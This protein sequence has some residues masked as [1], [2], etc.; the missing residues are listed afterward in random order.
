MK[1]TLTCSIAFIVLVVMS[2]GRATEDQQTTSDTTAISLLSEG[3]AVQIDKNIKPDTLHFAEEGAKK[4]EKFV[5]EVLPKTYTNRH[6]INVSGLS[7]DIFLLPGNIVKL[8]PADSTY[9]LVTVKALVNKGS[10]PSIT[11]ID[12]GIL[13]SNKINRNA[14]FNASFIIGGVSADANSLVELVIQDISKSVLPD[15]AID[16]KS[17]NKIV[18]KIPNGSLSSYFFIKTAVLTTVNH[19]KFKSANFNAK[20]NATYVTAEG[21]VFS[22]NEKFVSE[23]MVSIDLIS[24]ADI[25][26]QPNSVKVKRTTLSEL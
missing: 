14:A 13:Y 12:N 17:L 1:M 7:Y 23:R 11:A 20:V 25:I 8:N 24:F 2:C 21:K 15:T 5:N 4:A 16:V 9:Q 10:K 22:S 19:K 3:I 26:F 6:F 18:A